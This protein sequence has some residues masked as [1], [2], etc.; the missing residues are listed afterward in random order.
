MTARGRRGMAGEQAARG[1]VQGSHTRRVLGLGRGIRPN[2]RRPASAFVYGV[3]AACRRGQRG[4]T[5]DVVR[6]DVLPVLH[7]GLALFD[8]LL[9][10]IFQRKWTK[11][12]TAKL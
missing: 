12:S 1:T 9:L 5:R 7:F 3:L 11:R 8:R 6:A 2:R 4:L 10:K